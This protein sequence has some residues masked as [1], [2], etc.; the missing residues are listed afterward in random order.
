MEKVLLEAR[1]RK[2]GTKSSRNELRRNGR[3]PGIYYS[4]NDKPVAF[5][6]AENSVNPLVFTAENHLLG[7]KLED[8]SEYDCIIK[9]VQFDPVTDKIIHFDLI[10]LIKGETLQL[11][12]PVSLAGTAVGVRE[13]GVLQH[14]LHKLQIECLPADIP[15][16]IEL[17]IANLKLGEAI[18]V[19]EIKVENVKFL[20]PEDAVVVA[21]T[22]PKVTKEAEPAEAE[23]P[24]EP[25]VIGKGKTEKEEETEE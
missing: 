3:V 9:D 2:T 10:G 15:Q 7:L 23:E 19:S 6:V 18:H 12:V 1:I 24:A 22:H 8:G 17:D 21:V 25:E 5:D 11:E 13:G 14:V 4:K 16:H 20:N